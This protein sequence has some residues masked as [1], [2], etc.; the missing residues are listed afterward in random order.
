MEHGGNADA[1]AETLRIGGNCQP[2]LGCRLEQKVVD[3]RLVLEGNVGDLGGQC[4]DDWK[5]P[6]GRR[7]ASRSASQVREAAP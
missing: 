1:R 7:S 5:Y 6:T 2:R 3:Q 4:E